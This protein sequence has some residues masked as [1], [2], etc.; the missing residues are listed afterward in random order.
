MKKAAHL[1]TFCFLFITGT[2]FSQSTRLTIPLTPSLDFHNS[3]GQLMSPV[4]GVQA[5]GN[6]WALYQWGTS[7]NLPPVTSSSTSWTS[8]NAASA[9]SSQI[10][11]GYQSYQ[12]AQNGAS[13][14]CPNEFDLFLQ[15][16]STNGFVNS[17]AISTLGQVFITAGLD[18]IYAAST[19]GCSV[20]ANGH[21]YSI[22]LSSATGQTLFYQIDLGGSASGSNMAWCPY[23]YE[24]SNN[25][26]YCVDD[27]VRVLGGNYATTGT[28]VLN[29]I[30]ILPRILQILGSQHKKTSYP[31]QQL[32]SNPANWKITGVYA[33]SH[34]WGNTQ[35]TANWY[36]LSTTTMPGGAFCS[37]G[38]VV[39]YSCSNGIPSGS[40]WVSVGGGCYQRNSGVSC[41]GTSLP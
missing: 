4:S 15:N 40:G 6:S 34:V 30:D 9:V 14:A 8:A 11:S 41:T 24:D 2:A 32:D 25:P 3:A 10:Y 37:A 38:T 13:V 20:T 35:V 19:A 27:D 17:A 31:N 33:G 12:M 23:G 39:Q 26:L 22:L 36:A 16:D 28:N 21:L 7:S 1:I 5:S 18:I 29:Q